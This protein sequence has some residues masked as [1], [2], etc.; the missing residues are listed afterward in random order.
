MPLPCASTKLLRRRCFLRD[1]VL[2]QALCGSD[3]TRQQCISVALTWDFEQTGHEALH[4]NG[5]MAYGRE[6]LGTF[7][8]LG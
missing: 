8:L 5:L 2:G 7:A 1:S 3:G 4:G 6:N